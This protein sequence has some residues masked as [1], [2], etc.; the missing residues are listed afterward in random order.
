MSAA[1]ALQA[2]LSAAGRGWPVFPV[3]PG[4]KRPAVPDHDATNCTGTDPRCT[5]GHLGWQPRASTDPDR[6]RRGWATTAFNVGIACGPAGLVVLDLD[7]PKPGE[8]TPPPAWRIDGVHNG[9]D[10]LAVL[11]ERAGE[12]FAALF[13][14]YTVT[15]GRGGRHLYYTAPPDANLGNTAK[16]LGWLIDTRAH[17]GYVL[18]AGSIVAGR[19]YVS[20][21]DVPPAALPAWMLQ[22]LSRPAP[23]P[24]VP[25]T[26]ATGP[27]RRGAYLNA[28]ICR[29]VDR[30]TTADE[31]AR[32]AALYRAAVAL[33][34]LVAGN[35]LPALEVQALLE[36]AAATAGHIAAGAY[37][38]T[39]ARATIASGL[40]TG[41]KRPR[42]VAA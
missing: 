39:E 32:N 35:A 17:G 23:P 19:R 27:G 29:E 16:E 11:A 40:R 33:G 5:Q 3:R 41:A 26:I 8:Q 28:A 14:T 18:G 7:I 30:V 31:G 22:R 1:R 6:I 36:H 34:Q 21:N 12:S 2:A 38:T 37:S 25:V 20:D 9:E 15:T 10:V 42:T 24:A 4:G 13:D